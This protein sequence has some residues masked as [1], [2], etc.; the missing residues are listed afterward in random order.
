MYLF[1]III[2]Q[3]EFKN[4]QDVLNIIQKRLLLKIQLELINILVIS[5][6]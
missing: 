6:Y 2:C 1:I 5:F 3:S 4:N